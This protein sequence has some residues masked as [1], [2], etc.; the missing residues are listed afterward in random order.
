MFTFEKHRLKHS[1]PQFYVKESFYIFNK[2]QSFCTRLQSKYFLH[3]FRNFRSLGTC[4]STQFWNSTS[5]TDLRQQY[6]YNHKQ[7]ALT[8]TKRKDIFLWL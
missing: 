6:N 1:Q 4:N 5:V 2:T 3:Q 7:T 8:Q